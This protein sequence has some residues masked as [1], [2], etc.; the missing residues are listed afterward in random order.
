[1]DNNKSRKMWG[2]LISE[3]EASKNLG[4]K[5][6]IEFRRWQTEEGVARME[7]EAKLRAAE[8]DRD[9]FKW[10]GKRMQ[11]VLEFIE[12]KDVKPIEQIV[13]Q[14]DEDYIKWMVRVVL[15]KEVDWDNKLKEFLA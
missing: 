1:M 6:I 9:N 7:L 8:S 5:D 13:G 2:E 14:S 3:E 12:E 11:K 15:G 10:H 4:F